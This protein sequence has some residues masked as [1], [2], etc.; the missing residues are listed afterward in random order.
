[1]VKHQFVALHGELVCSSDEVDGIIMRES[2]GDI[3]AEKEACSARGKTPT[4]DIYNNPNTS[5][6]FVSRTLFARS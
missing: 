5:L 4:G 1:L 3:R 6:D 2:L